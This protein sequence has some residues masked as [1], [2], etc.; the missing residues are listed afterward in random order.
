MLAFN[1]E[2][3]DDTERPNVRSEVA[4][5]PDQEHLRFGYNR[6][7]DQIP[8]AAILRPISEY[9]AQSLRVPPIFEGDP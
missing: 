6:K 2:P 3:S 1:T 4:K 5:H 8:L 7:H 9:Q